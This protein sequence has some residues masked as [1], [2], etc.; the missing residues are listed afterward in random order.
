MRSH[1][2]QFT[3]GDI[4]RGIW[5]AGA[6][7]LALSLVLHATLAMGWWPKRWPATDVDRTILTHQIASAERAHD[8]AVVLVGDSSCLMDI[9]AALLGRLTGQRVLNL[10]TLSYLGLDAHETL[11]RRY[12]AHNPPPTDVILALHPEA[13][14]QISPSPVHEQFFARQVG[15]TSGAPAAFS[16]EYVRHATGMAA[17]RDR[18]ITRTASVPLTGAFG[19]TYKFASEV[20]RYLG[21]AF[22]EPA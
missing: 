19:R 3:I 1:V 16:L 13:L 17:L 15:G 20:E 22:R 5:P 2:N 11:L 8:A 7:V 9:D 18:L 21:S 4:W 6:V 10:G 14:R 12:L